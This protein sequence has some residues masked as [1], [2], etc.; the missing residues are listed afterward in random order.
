MCF[1]ALAEQN[2][3]KPP[4]SPACGK[5]QI[6]KTNHLDMAHAKLPFYTEQCFS[7][8][9]RAEVAELAWARGRR[10]RGR[11]KQTSPSPIFCWFQAPAQ[12]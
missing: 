2:K 4:S 9:K 12:P 8:R 11:L 6:P 7:G 10:Q 1:T 3:Y 5:H